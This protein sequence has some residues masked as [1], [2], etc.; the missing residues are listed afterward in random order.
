MMNQSDVLKALKD[1]RPL[2]RFEA[3]YGPT[4]IAGSKV[5]EVWVEYKDEYETR[6]VEEAADGTPVAIH[7]TFQSLALR[8]DDLHLAL[9]AR[10]QDVERDKTMQL[11]EH[12]SKLASDAADRASK[13]LTLMIRDVS[14]AGAFAVSLILF[15]YLLV[16]SSNPWPATFMFACVIA[17]ACAFFYGR[18][19]TP[20]IP[21]N[22]ISP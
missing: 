11:A 13:R 9:M 10:L 4:R 1:Q 21:G 18:F 22:A 12:Q 15:G 2:D 19:I 6:F 8:L 5:W 7:D 14:T 17:S 16:M 3:M 20:K